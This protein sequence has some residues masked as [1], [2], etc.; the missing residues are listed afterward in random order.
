MLRNRLHDAEQKIQKEVDNN[1]E[2]PP[3]STVVL[4]Q[5]TDIP[6]HQDNANE[7]DIEHDVTDDNSGNKELN[8]YMN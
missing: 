6:P 3:S 4:E 7:K 5:P 1:V 2:M 8:A